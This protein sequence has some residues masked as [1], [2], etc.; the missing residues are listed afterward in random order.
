MF[1]KSSMHIIVKISVLNKAWLLLTEDKGG[2][3]GQETRGRRGGLKPANSK[4][5]SRSSKNRRL[6][7]RIYFKMF[8]VNE[9]LWDHHWIRVHPQTPKNDC[10]LFFFKERFESGTKVRASQT[11]PGRFHRRTR[12]PPMTGNARQQH[13]GKWMCLCV[14]VQPVCLTAELYVHSLNWD[15]AF[16]A[17]WANIESAQGNKRP[18]SLC[19]NICFCNTANTLCVNRASATLSVQIVQVYN[20][21]SHRFGMFTHNK[22][23]DGLTNI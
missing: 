12:E 1:S 9:T 6:T 7:L 19:A 22:A 16:G 5:D 21:T 8:Y 23:A 11:S 20:N 10:Y 4:T 14:C 2:G 18:A 13:Q 17:A 15:E 3:W